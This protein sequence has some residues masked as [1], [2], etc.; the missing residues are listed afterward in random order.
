[1]ENVR[2][3]PSK[4]LACALPGRNRSAK[5]WSLRGHRLDVLHGECKPKC[6][7]SGGLGKDQ[8]C[9]LPLHGEQRPSGVPWWDVTRKLVD[10]LGRRVPAINVRHQDGGN[11]LDSCWF[12]LERTAVRVAR[13]SCG[14]ASCQVWTQLKWIR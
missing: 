4:L 1:M 3:L 10:Q 7:I 9:Y 11:T 12:G 13:K 2:E 8:A 6:R 5:A 14:T